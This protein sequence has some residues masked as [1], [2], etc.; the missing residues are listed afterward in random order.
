MKILKNLGLKIVGFTNENLKN[1]GLKIV[2]FTKEN[3]EKFWAEN[4]WFY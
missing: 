3:F 1:F 2:G 4:C